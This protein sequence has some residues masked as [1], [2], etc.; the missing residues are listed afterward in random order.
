MTLFSLKSFFLIAAYRIMNLI[1]VVVTDASNPLKPDQATFLTYLSRRQ[2]TFQ[3]KLLT[4]DETVTNIVQETAVKVGGE[5]KRNN[6][7]NWHQEHTNVEKLKLPNT[8][9]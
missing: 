7:I 6:T 2:V 1:F 5:K 9:E 4:Q 8:N 3:R